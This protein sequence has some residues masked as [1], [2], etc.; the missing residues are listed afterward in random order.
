MSDHVSLEEATINP[1]GDVDVVAVFRDATHVPS[2]SGKKSRRK[3]PAG[4]EPVYCAGTIPITAFPS[5]LDIS[6]ESE[7]ELIQLI[8][9][10]QLLPFAEGWKFL[11]IAG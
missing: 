4:S 11:T 2:T 6:G 3:T 5:W 9:H 8:E 10:F 7:V 1:A